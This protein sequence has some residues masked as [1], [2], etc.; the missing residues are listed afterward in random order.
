M[1]LAKDKHERYLGAQRAQFELADSLP[2]RSR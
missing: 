1:S 2:H